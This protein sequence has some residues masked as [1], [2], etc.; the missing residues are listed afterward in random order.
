MEDH[1]VESEMV[2]LSGKLPQNESQLSELNRSDKKLRN[3]RAV[4]SPA[5]RPHQ[6]TSLELRDM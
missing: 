4:Q 1:G 5:I 2:H 3:D 6:N